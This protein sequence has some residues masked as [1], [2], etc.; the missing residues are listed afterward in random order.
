MIINVPSE[1]PTIQ[2]AIDNAN[3]GDTINIEPGPYDISDGLVINKHL[4]INGNNHNNNPT[5]GGIRADETIL[6]GQN[7]NRFIR[8]RDENITI[9]GMTIISNGKTAIWYNG[10][11][12]VSNLCVENNI[13]DGN[14]ECFGASTA[15]SGNPNA[16]NI[17]EF[18]NNLIKSN[19]LRMFSCY[20][21]VK[22]TN[23]SITG[24]EIEQ[25]LA[26]IHLA[27]VENITISDNIISLGN[28]TF[29]GILL[30]I[31]ISNIN[32]TNNDFTN[33]GFGISFWG[34]TNILDHVN[35]TY[36]K[37]FDISDAS[38]LIRQNEGQTTDSTKITVQ[39]NTIDSK[40]VNNGTG[41]L[42]VTNNWWETIDGEIIDAIIEGDANH[43]P[44]LCEPPPTSWF[45][46]NGKCVCKIS[47]S[48]I[49][50]KQKI[51]IITNNGNIIANAQN[52]EQSRC[53]CIGCICTDYS[54]NIF[55]TD[56]IQHSVFKITDGGIIS[57]LAGQPG[58]SGHNNNFT[59]PSLEAKF[60]QP[61]GIC[62]DQSG[63]IFICDTGN[64]Q[65]RK[66]TESHVSWVAGSPDGSS[67]SDDGNINVARFN[68]PRGIDVDNSG[69]LCIADTA[70]QVI[71]VINIPYVT[72]IAGKKGTTGNQPLWT[73]Q[74]NTG[75]YGL[76]AR[77]NNPLSLSTDANGNIYV[78]D[79][80]NYVIKKINTSGNVRVISGSGEFGT[81]TGSAPSCKYQIIN[82]IS[83]GRKST[84]PYVLDYNPDGLSR[85]IKIDENGKPY[86]ERTIDTQHLDKYFCSVIHNHSGDLIVG[87]R[88]IHQ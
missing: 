14:G 11:D 70:N 42:D 16:I 54:G 84:Y 79:T 58:V 85:M 82:S 67:G 34:E 25:S 48:I 5:R 73:N 77:F 27:T 47:H 78:A 44:W 35:I 74:P 76:N 38:I 33:S 24:N 72:T 86:P 50:F 60:N 64:N 40:I 55:F 6:N 13:F 65:I 31:D 57:L 9:S 37:F 68:Q 87:T 46:E 10:V 17:F 20:T 41:T 71:R 49:K 61:M 18:K 56:P 63:G 62:S 32:I 75:I 21:G 80:D 28:P 29:W 43:E 83:I 51:T 39:F 66:I 8:I 59:T 2:L 45:S 26:G 3:P 4:T 15:A 53:F 30:G 81:A 22:G 88:W 69:R 36:N 7:T 12:V 52:L 1:Y 19:T 23:F